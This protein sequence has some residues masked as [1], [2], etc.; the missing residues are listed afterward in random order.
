MCI[1]E[2]VIPSLSLE[3]GGF[4]LWR[5]TQAQ[6]LDDQVAAIQNV[7]LSNKLIIRFNKK[8]KLNI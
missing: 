3:E 7:Y 6:A 5:V 1:W 2:Y 4:E 8:K